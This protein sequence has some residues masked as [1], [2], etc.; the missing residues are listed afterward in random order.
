MITP[1]HKLAKAE[2]NED[3]AKAKLLCLDVDSSE[4]PLVAPHGVACV[5]LT[6]S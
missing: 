2:E 1:V 6:L 5:L 4:K 3:R